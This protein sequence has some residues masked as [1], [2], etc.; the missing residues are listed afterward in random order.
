[1][2]DA[3]NTKPVIGLLGGIGSGKSTVAREFARQGC[4]VIDA[5]EL[6]RAALREP[7]VRD[8]LV[9]WWGDAVLDAEGNVDRKAVGRIVF[10]QPDELRK[11]ESVTHPRVHAG[12]E[13]ARQAMQNDPAIVAIVED[14]PLLLESGLDESCDRLILV[15][16]S[17][18]TRL[19]RLQ[20]DRGWSES[21]LDRREKNQIPL[22]TKAQRADDVIDNDESAEPL[23]GQVRNVLSRILQRSI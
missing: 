9:A 3:P 12:R 2:T 7:N 23:V 16:A 22:D 5:D 14:C 11:L 19:H 8:Q 18:A 15:Q 20:R 21:E 13:S 4:G 1:M 17:R 6:A 10:D